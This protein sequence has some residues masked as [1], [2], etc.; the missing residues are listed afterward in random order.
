[1]VPAEPCA[2]PCAESAS[3]PHPAHVP[4]S[5]HALIRSHRPRHLARSACLFTVGQS[6]QYPPR[7]L[8]CSFSPLTS[9]RSRRHGRRPLPVGCVLVAILQAVSCPRRP[10]RVPL[11]RERLVSAPRAR[12]LV[13]PSPYM[14]AWTSPL[15]RSAYLFTDALSSQY[16]PRALS[17]SILLLTSTRSRR[18][19]RRPHPVCCDRLVAIP[20]NV[21]GPR[22]PLR[23]PAGRAR[24]V[25]APRAR[26]VVLPRP[27][28]I[29]QTAPP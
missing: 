13:L 12:P 20:Q 11:R 8:C 21:S 5:C 10:L 26:P 2:C 22:R 23:V 24:L 28:K 19:G 6:S 3:S 7:A 16:P 29:A 1:M 15:A 27:H 25:S 17:C 14:I 4:W 9:A 18:H